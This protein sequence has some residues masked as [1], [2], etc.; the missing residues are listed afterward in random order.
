MIARLRTVNAIL[1]QV[2][3]CRS[4]RKADLRC[5]DR[6]LVA[7]QNS[8]Y[9]VQVL[10]DSTYTVCGGWFDRHGLSPVRTS[11]AGCTWGGSVIK[12]D[13][14]AACGLHLEFGNRVVTSRIREVRVIRDGV[15]GTLQVRP[16]EE[17]ELLNACYGSPP[18]ESMIG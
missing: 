4:V 17:G 13:I 16:L 6:V 11:I 5:G 15:S 14:V 9:S 1:D 10:E 18:H 2:G 3:H 12:N 8:L 7:T